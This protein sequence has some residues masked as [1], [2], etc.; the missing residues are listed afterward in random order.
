[1]RN[2]IVESGMSFVA[3]N[4]FHIEESPLYKRLG[5][6]VK[7]VEF[8]RSKGNKL[9]F[10]EAKSSFPNPNS[11]TPNP[12]K[13]NKIG[14][15]LFRDE[16]FDL[17]EKFIHSL[18]LYSSVEVGVTDDKFPP[19]YMP[20]EKVSLAFIFVINIKIFDKSSCLVIERALLNIIRESTCMLRI[21]KPE[22]YVL[23]HEMAT[24]W[25]LTIT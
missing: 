19:E 23:T 20:S 16:I 5:K 8:V 21:W 15:E 9:L 25:E 24:K 12:N 4:V 13:G 7:S 10:V 6:K 2:V 14:S 3:D 22:V 17:C 11:L 18:N 1:M